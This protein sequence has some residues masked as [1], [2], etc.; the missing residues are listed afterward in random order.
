MRKIVE[1]DLYSGLSFITRDGKSAK[2]LN[3][4]KNVN[5]KNEL[6]FLSDGLI[7]GCDIEGKCWS[8]NNFD[9]KYTDTVFS[10]YDVFIDNKVILYSH[11]YKNTVNGQYYLVDRQLSFTIEDAIKYKELSRHED[12]KLIEIKIEE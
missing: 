1:S 10:K 7:L 5:P 9:E 3:V 8:V 11:V 12:A 4:V 2:L 6:L